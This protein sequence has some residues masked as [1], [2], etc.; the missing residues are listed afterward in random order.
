MRRKIARRVRKQIIRAGAKIKKEH[1][2]KEPG[3]KRK[4]CGYSVD[5]E[6][7]GWKI[8]ACGFDKL[9]TYRDLLWAINCQ[10]EDD[11]GR[12]D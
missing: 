1:W 11:N 7:C 6:Y 5:I 9:E 8:F 12:C 4:D 2:V 10:L 3:W